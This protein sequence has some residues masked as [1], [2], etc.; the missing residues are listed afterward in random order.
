MSSTAFQRSIAALCLNEIIIVHQYFMSI[1]IFHK[2]IV[3]KELLKSYIKRKTENMVQN[4]TRVSILV[5]GNRID[6]TIFKYLYVQ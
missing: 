5:M 4:N 2:S 1:V 6:N 3:R